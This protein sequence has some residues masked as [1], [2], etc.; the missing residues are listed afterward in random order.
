MVRQMVS[1]DSMFIFLN[2]SVTSCLVHRCAV[3]ATFVLCA[4]Q[5]ASPVSEDKKPTSFLAAHF[6]FSLL[7]T[8]VV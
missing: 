3:S 1:C 2:I 6:N 4:K 5:F 8:H 7:V